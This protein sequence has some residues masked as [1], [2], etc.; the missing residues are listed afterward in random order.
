M[1]RRKFM[2]ALAALGISAAGVSAVSSAT[3]RPTFP[4]KSAPTVPLDAQ[5]TQNLQLHQQHLAHQ[6]RGNTGALHQDYAEHAVVEDS[7]YSAPF[8]GRSAIMA[9]KG[10]GMAAI[11]DVKI[12]VTNRVA[13]GSQVVAEW[14]ATGT[15]TG[16][17]PGLPASNRPFSIR[18]VTVVVRHE[19]K[20]VREAIYYDMGEVRR[21]LSQ[22]P[23]NNNMNEIAINPS[24]APNLKP[25]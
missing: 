11:P 18:G 19:G 10:V 2:K 3:I 22:D 5:P 14:T 21:Q 24:T 23:H 6:S 9:R 12:Q 13:H 25:L 15:H 8:V 4:S 7:M 1:P 20:I 17:F 16:D